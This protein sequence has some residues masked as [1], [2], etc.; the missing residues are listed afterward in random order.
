MHLGYHN[1][2]FFYIYF[3]E[4]TNLYPITPHPLQIYEGDYLT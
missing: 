2:F 3:E 1:I 4:Y